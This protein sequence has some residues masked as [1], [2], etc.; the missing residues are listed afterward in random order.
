MNNAPLSFNWFVLGLDVLFALGV[1]HL[2][3]GLVYKIGGK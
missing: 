1:L 2:D 3:D